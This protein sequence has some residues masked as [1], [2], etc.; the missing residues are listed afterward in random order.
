M[1]ATPTTP[2]NRS[3]D[4]VDLNADLGESFG[5]WQL[6]DDD[7]MLAL[8]TSANVAGGF[9]AGDPT[10]LRRACRTAVAN[11]VVIGAQVG[12]R[13]LAGFGRRFIDIAA[14]DL[15]ADIIYQVGALDALA[16]SSGGTVCYLKPHGGLYNA[17]VDHAEQAQAVVDALLALPRRLPVM[18]LPGSA[19][20][21]IAAD[22][23]L[24]PVTEYFVDRR[25]TDDGRLVD[26]RRPDA[27]ITDPDTAA[28]RAVRAARDGVAD[29]FCLHGD[30]P[31]AVRMAT[32]VRRTLHEAGITI[33]PFTGQIDQAP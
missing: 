6:G 16:A 27:L 2:T 29:S 26:R 32:T 25:Y 24:E 8:I 22:N 13:D 21:R 9:H 17:V 23:G 19:L 3:C 15:T 20:L 11:Q 31:D 30:S 4:G 33:R 7:A 5:R 18:G 14:D 28:D 10:T 1:A 12:Y